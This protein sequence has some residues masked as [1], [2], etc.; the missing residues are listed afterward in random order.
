MDVAD[1]AGPG[2]SP[3]IARL[4]QQLGAD[5]GGAVDAFWREVEARDAPLIEPLADDGH[6]LVTFLWRARDQR[7][8]PAAA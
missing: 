1:T 5:R 4:R 7:D 3:R 8:R 6:A 2:Q